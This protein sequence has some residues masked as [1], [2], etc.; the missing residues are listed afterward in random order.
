[1]EWSHPCPLCWLHCLAHPYRLPWCRTQHNGQGI[2]HFLAHE[3]QWQAAMTFHYLH[4]LLT[5]S[6]DKFVIICPKLGQ[7]IIQNLHLEF[8]SHFWKQQEDS[9]SWQH[10][11]N[12]HNYLAT[13]TGSKVKDW[14]KWWSYEPYYKKTSHANTWI[15][16]STAKVEYDRKNFSDIIESPSSSN[17]VCVFSVGFSALVEPGSCQSV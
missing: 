7:R 12:K 2:E 5:V 14:I 15:Q 13:P 9:V 17:I 3:E 16:L 8:L 11:N 10:K 1:M 6:I 4:Q